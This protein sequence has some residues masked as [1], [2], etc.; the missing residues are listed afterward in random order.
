M[1]LAIVDDTPEDIQ[2]LRQCLDRFAS[3]KSLTMQVLEFSDAAAFLDRYTAD[4]DMVFMDIRMPYLDGMTAAQRLRELDSTVL[5]VFVTSLSQYAV[6]S[7]TVEAADYIVKPLNYYDFSLK[8][9]RLLRRL[10]SREDGELLLQTR[11][12]VVRLRYGQL[13]YIESRGHQLI[14]YTGDRSYEQRGSLS[15]LEKSLA[16]HGFARCSSCYLVNL[17]YVSAIK[18]YTATVAGTGL[19]ISQPRKKAF[20]QAL[21]A[22][23]GGGGL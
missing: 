4:Y 14:Y 2:R 1:K 8:F 18:G 19:Q 11:D 22:Y 5:L 20:V 13:L 17:K 3:E 12:E 7:Y 10:H 15:A 6:R 21:I 23:T 16:P 9:T